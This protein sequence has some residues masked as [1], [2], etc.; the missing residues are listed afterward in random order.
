MNEDWLHRW[1]EGRIGWHEPAGNAALKTHWPKLGAGSR[2]LVPLCGKSLDLLWLAERGLDVTGIEM[3]TVAIETFFAE[4]RLE[5][6]KV[7][8][9]LDCYCA[10]ERE[11]RLYRGDFFEFSGEPFDAVYDR[12]ALV[13]I[14]RDVRP[15]YAAHLD[16]L[17]RAHAFRFLVTLEY[18][19]VRVAGPPFAL[20]PDEVRRYWP[21]LRRVAAH[22]DI[23]NCPPKFRDAGVNEVAEVVW[24]SRRPG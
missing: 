5:Y 23:D 15:H 20:M 13:A 7:S 1:E 21:Q 3:S 16:T 17:L 22:D 10:R 2:V 4:Q 24:C 14:P 19:Q 12:G 6:E 18:D 11:I 9:A 8:G